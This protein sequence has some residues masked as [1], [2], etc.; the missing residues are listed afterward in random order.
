V[1]YSRFDERFMP[2]FDRKWEHT[3]WPV[4]VKHCAP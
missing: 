1:W 3:A 2:I 4:D